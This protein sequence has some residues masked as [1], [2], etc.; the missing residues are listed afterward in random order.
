MKILKALML[1]LMLTLSLGSFAN[2]PDEARTNAVGE[3][4]GC[5]SNSTCSECV[6]QGTGD[7][8]TAAATTVDE[9]DDDRAARR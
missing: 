1:S 5:G 8:E 4:D 3:V 6:N 9:T 7:A 2:D